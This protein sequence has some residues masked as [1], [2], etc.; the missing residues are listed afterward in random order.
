MFLAPSPPELSKN[1]SFKYILSISGT[2]VP[3]QKHILYSLKQRHHSTKEMSYFKKGRS[4]TWKAD[5][6]RP[7]TNNC[8]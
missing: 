6:H 2:K 5:I 3:L 4:L 8:T 1:S 7:Q